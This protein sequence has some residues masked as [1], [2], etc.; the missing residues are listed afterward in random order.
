MGRNQGWWPPPGLLVLAALMSCMAAAPAPAHAA[1]C[2][3]TLPVDAAFLTKN[4]RA[5]RTDVA[6]RITTRGPAIRHL[7]AALY[8]Y[9]GTLVARGAARGTI[10]DVQ[11]VR[12]K[13]A[14][15]LEPRHYTLVI[16]GE[17]NAS[18]SCG[19]KRFTQALKFTSDCRPVLPVTFP[20]L[21][22][23]KAADYGG[24]VTFTLHAARALGAARVTISSYGGDFL[25]A[26]DLSRFPAGTAPL[27]VTLRKGLYASGYTIF[28]EGLLAD[29]PA[30]CGKK[31][32]KATF[33]LT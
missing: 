8:T 30:S 28:I 1:G 29:A 12:M 19:P 16:D 6:V 17:P 31:T 22:S 14:R 3:T 20:Q 18:R 5:Y 2:I 11:V 33:T 32:A 13:L 10:G 24:A 21:P 9:H 26:L 25:G 15:A 23:G 4:I 7:T 27:T